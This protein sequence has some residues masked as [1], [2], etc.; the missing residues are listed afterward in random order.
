M[1]AEGEG[2]EVAAT[3]PTEGICQGGAPPPCGR[4]EIAEEQ[5]S[6][7][8]SVRMDTGP[9]EYPTGFVTNFMIP[10]NLFVNYPGTGSLDITLAIMDRA[11]FMT[12]TARKFYLNFNNPAAILQFAA[13]YL[14]N[15]GAMGQA[16]TVYFAIFEG[17]G[18]ANNLIHGYRRVVTGAGTTT[19]TLGEIN[20]PIYPA[21]AESPGGN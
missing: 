1:W 6:G 4:S 7:P 19:V 12:R 13:T 17:F 9:C 20:L 5:T 18:C 15:P 21:R 8:D 14:N 16:T 3:G 10:R 11:Q 2:E